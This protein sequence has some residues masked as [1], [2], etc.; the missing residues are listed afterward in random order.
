M[1]TAEPCATGTSACASAKEGAA[2]HIRKAPPTH[3][4]KCFQRH[5]PPERKER[6]E[7]QK[8]LKRRAAAER[9]YTMV[10]PLGVYILQQ[11]RHKIARLSQSDPSPSTRSARAVSCRQSCNFVST[12][13]VIAAIS[14]LS[15]NRMRARTLSNDPVFRHRELTEICVL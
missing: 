11:P 12:A 6:A 14:R 7:R 5:A 10:A 13:H 2:R 4:I 1:R 3:T 15:I 9:Q 8:K